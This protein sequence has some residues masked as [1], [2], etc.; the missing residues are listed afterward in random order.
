M[1]GTEAAPELSR[2]SLLGTAAGA[3]TAALLGATAAGSAAAQDD[4]G[5][6]FT[7]D[8]KGGAVDNYDGTV[9][10]M[11]GQSAVTIETGAEGNGGSFAFAPPAVRVSPGTEVTFEWTSDTHNVLVEDQ[12]DGAQWDGHEPIENTGFSF[13]RTFEVEGIYT[14]YCDPHLSLGMKGAVVVAPPGSGGGDGDGGGG[15]GGQAAGGQPG[16]DL[17]DGV[18]AVEGAFFGFQL[19][20]LLTPF[21][22]YYRKRR[23]TVPAEYELP[24]VSDGDGVPEAPT[25][26]PTREIDHDEYDPIGTFSTIVVYF[27]ILVVMWVFVYFVEF[28]GNGPTVIG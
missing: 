26:E 6:W 2:R 28:L 19:V 7:D 17:P 25:Q 23:R 12:P 22:L 10:D 27:L 1:T 11:T 9:A 24:E 8:A 20:A 18:T 21:L 5:G 15:D 16:G 14:Y 13:S 3:G 4:F